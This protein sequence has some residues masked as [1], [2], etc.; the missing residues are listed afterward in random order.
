[1]K[2]GYKILWTYHALDE[3]EETYSYLEQIKQ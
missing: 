2:S 3:L 1:M